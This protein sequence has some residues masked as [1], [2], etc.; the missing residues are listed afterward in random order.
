MVDTRAQEHYG[1][2]TQFEVFA[3]HHKD[4]AIQHLGMVRA[5]DADDAEVFAYTMYDER[6][7]TEL[8]VAPRERMVDVI[9]PR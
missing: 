5:V 4:P 2:L 3:R 6:R 9:P 8:F 7:W 1:R